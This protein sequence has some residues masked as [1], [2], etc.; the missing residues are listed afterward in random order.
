MLT[1]FVLF[2]LVARAQQEAA[3][4]QQDPVERAAAR[5]LVVLAIIGAGVTIYSLLKYRGDGGRAGVLGFAH[6]R[7]RCGS[8]ADNG[9]RN[10]PGIRKS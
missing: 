2:P 6:R 9:R 7:C 1:G 8:V 3:R 4:F 10:H 5:F